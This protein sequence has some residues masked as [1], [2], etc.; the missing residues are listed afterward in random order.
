[1][2]EEC[3]C[4]YQEGM[5]IGSIAQSRQ[6]PGSQGIK[7]RSEERRDRHNLHL[8]SWICGKRMRLLGIFALLAL[9][10]VKVL[11]VGK[12][13]EACTN[14]TIRKEWRSLT[15]A[16]QANWISAVKVRRD[17]L[18]YPHVS[19]IRSV[20]R[21]HTGSLLLQTNQYLGRKRDS[22]I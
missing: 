6:Y 14:P 2:E 8:E 13:G 11:G 21:K 5:L 18:S 7:V 10:V 15:K 16:E 22:K 9:A 4:V 3:E 12:P 19:H 20:P 1:L 17:S